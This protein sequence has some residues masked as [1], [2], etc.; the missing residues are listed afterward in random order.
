M[1]DEYEI[2][3]DH[4]HKTM[5]E[6]RPD[7]IVNTWSGYEHFDPT[8]SIISNKVYARITIKDNTIIWDEYKEFYNDQ[9]GTISFNGGPAQ[10]IIHMRISVAI[11][12]FSIADPN[13]FEEFESFIKIHKIK[14]HE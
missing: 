13:C 3:T 12:K 9:S 4:L 14:K 10:P 1:V 6:A 5:V 2:I 11:K 8:I 7:W